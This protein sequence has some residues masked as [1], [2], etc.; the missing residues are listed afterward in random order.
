MTRQ[1]TFYVGTVFSFSI[2]S[3][4]HLFLNQQNALILLSQLVFVVVGFLF[5]ILWWVSTYG[6]AAQKRALED[7]F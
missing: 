2:A 3:L 6:S 7:K 5:L 1:K 4:S